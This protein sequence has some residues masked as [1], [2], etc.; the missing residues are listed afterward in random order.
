MLRQEVD[1]VMARHQE[2]VAQ[3]EAATAADEAQLEQRA[4]ALEVCAHA[5]TT[6]SKVS[7]TSMSPMSS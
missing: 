6:P 1:R 5:V 4:A 3:W 7:W 2:R